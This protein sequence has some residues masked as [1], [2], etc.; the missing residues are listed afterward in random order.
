VCEFIKLFYNRTFSFSVDITQAEL[1][2]SVRRLVTEYCPSKTD[3]DDYDIFLDLK[4]LFNNP[5]MS[6]IILHKGG[7]R[8]N[9]LW[10]QIGIST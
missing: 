7:A 6:D 4:S 5:E 9:C 10:S 8:K 3:K 2:K 1:V